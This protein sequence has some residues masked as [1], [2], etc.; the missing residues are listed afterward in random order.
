MYLEI[1]LVGRNIMRSCV[2]LRMLVIFLTAGLEYVKVVYFLCSVFLSVF[3][4]MVVHFG[5]S[6]CVC[7]SNVQ[8]YLLNPPVGRV[9][10]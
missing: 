2:F 5:L 10:V 3:V 9:Y 8:G 7:V 6:C 1:V 4:K